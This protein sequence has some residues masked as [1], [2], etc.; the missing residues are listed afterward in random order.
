MCGQERVKGQIAT[1][2]GRLLMLAG[3]LEVSLKRAVALLKI[4]IIPGA[5]HTKSSHIESFTYQYVVARTDA[6]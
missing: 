3:T 4:S 5:V 6:E 2:F 1:L